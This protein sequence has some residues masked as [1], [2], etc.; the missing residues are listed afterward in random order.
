MIEHVCLFSCVL[1]LFVCLSVCLFFACLPVCLSPSLCLFVC[2]FVCLS[3]WVYTGLLV[4]VCVWVG[5]LCFRMCSCFCFWLLAVL[6][7][8]ICSFLV[9]HSFFFLVFFFPGWLIF[10]CH[11]WLEFTQVWCR[12]LVIV[13]VVGW[14]FL[15]V[16][17]ASCQLLNLLNANLLE[18]PAQVVFCWAPTV[19]ARWWVNCLLWRTRRHAC[20][21]VNI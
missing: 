9:C 16:S 12:S 4:C 3:F 19:W 8:L 6:L 1:A 15:G 5:G 7:S 10:L 20:V 21:N 2:L 18:R 14:C 11:S 17:A 13:S